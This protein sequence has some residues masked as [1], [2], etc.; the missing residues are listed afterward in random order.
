MLPPQEF[1]KKVMTENPELGK[2]LIDI[3]AEIS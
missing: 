2:F 1:L 3:D